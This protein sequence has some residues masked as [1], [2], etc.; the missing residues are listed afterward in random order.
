MYESTSVIRVKYLQSRVWLDTMGYSVSAKAG[1]TAEFMTSISCE[2]PS[3]DIF[4]YIPG[5]FVLFL[6]EAS[7]K[8]AAEIRKSHTGALS[9]CGA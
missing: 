1:G 2:F 5:F 9:E 6:I 4:I 3:R 8:G 7:P